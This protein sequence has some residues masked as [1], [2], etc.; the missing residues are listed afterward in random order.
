MT[1]KAAIDALRNDAAVW[2]E[3]ASTT[4]GAGTAAAGLGLTEADMSF[5]AGQ[6]GLVTTYNALK[7][8]VAR[9]LT[10]GG[11][12]QHELAV[13]L[14]RVAGAYEASDERAAGKFEGVWVVK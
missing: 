5:G 10:E 14:D 3:V 8:R 11:Q 2:D 4:S 12:V 13:T 9:L 6:T 7:D 1:L